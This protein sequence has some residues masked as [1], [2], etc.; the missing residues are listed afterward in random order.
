M[1]EN[2]CT[3]QKGKIVKSA[4][5][6]WQNAATTKRISCTDFGHL[7]IHDS[8]ENK[9]KNNFA[10]S[11]F[12]FPFLFSFFLVCQRRWIDEKL[13]HHRVSLCCSCAALMLR[14]PLSW[15]S[16]QRDSPLEHWISWSSSPFPFWHTCFD[17]FLLLLIVVPKHST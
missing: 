1:A 5:H 12:H 11:S 8:L 6:V 13:S 3:W 4:F 14:I 2:V 15:G 10:S 9:Q 17:V 7:N 16:C